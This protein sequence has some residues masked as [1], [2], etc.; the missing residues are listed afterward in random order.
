MAGRRAQHARGELTSTVPAKSLRWFTRTEEVSG[1]M[2]VEL[3]EPIVPNHKI[4]LNWA[5]TLQ[6][7][8]T[9]WDE[10]VELG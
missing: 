8:N 10:P 7:R 2:S 1:L 3:L 5:P 6:L 9:L 4:V